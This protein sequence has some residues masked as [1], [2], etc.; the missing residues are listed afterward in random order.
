MII[1]ESK[2]KNYT[3]ITANI[4]FE[5]GTA[6]VDNLSDD[7]RNWFKELGCK[8]EEIKEEEIKEEE[9]KEEKIKEE[10]IKEE[11]IKEEKK[12]KAKPEKGE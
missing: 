9:I 7:L 4:P 5:N 6:K 8:V 3:G 12:T 1:I 2:N 10:K 11:K